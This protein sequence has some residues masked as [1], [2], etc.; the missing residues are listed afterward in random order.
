M[1]LDEERVPQHSQVHVDRS[2]RLGARVPDHGDTG[3]QSDPYGG[4]GALVVRRV[5]LRSDRD[6]PAAPSP[7]IATP[8]YTNTLMRLFLIA[9]ATI[10]R[11]HVAVGAMIQSRSGGPIAM[12]LLR[13]LDSFVVE[14]AGT[15][16]RDGSSVRSPPR[17]K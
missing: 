17:W 10:G 1:D 14:L 16:S 13:Y 15:G 12:P 8:T 3:P 4:L 11:G 2:H 5:R 9:P 7:T 6:G